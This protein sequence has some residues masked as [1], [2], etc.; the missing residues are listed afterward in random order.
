MG[1]IAVTGASGNVGSR[2]IGRLAAAGHRVR[3]ISRNP[4]AQPEG[5][6]VA[7]ADLTD[8]AQAIDV[9][10][11]ADSAYLNLP[12]WGEDPLGMETAVGTNLIDAAAKTG[13]SNVVMHTALHADR[14]DTGAR[15]LDN[16]TALEEAL[17]GSGVGHTILRPAWFLQNL[18]G[19][20]DYLTQ[21]VVSLPWA[22]DMVWAA[23]DVEDIV[24]AAVAFLTTEPA[25]RG[26]DL[27]I[28]GGISGDGIAAAAGRVLGREVAYMEA[29]VSTRDY[30]E[31]FPIGDVHKDIYAELFDYFRSTTY[32][33]EPGAVTEAV[34]GLSYRGVEDFLRDEL[35]AGE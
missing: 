35:F 30:V 32:L 1:L 25:N 12:Y 13:V 33:G 27:H 6:E 7:P 22:G 2:I 34:E 18:W 11:G 23:T 19:A 15:I 21:G 4:G 29:Q 26:F 8:L 16:K 3:A 20:R 31:G 17:A 5:V 14:G 10:D 28:S 9:L 24:T